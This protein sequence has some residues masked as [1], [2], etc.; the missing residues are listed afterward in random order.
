VRARFGFAIAALALTLAGCGELPRESRTGAP[1]E[2]VPAREGFIEMFGGFKYAELSFE[3]EE[4]VRGRLPDDA[5]GGVLVRR[6]VGGG[7]G[8][9]VAM[10]VPNQRRSAVGNLLVREARRE[11]EQVDPREI[12]VSA[13][14]DLAPLVV[15]DPGPEERY[16]LV[17]QV[18][19]HAVVLF[20]RDEREI[21]A[22]GAAFQPTGPLRSP[23]SS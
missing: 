18:D 5:Q 14:D 15:Y 20:G 11:G 10:V 6:I 22:M 12:D 1:C 23:K 19:C 21:T 4:D 13:P 17:V 2:D 3:A 7:E 9:K 16:A 8:P